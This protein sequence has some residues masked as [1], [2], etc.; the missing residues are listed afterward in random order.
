MD[1]SVASGRNV[2]A[3]SLFF[4][5]VD[6]AERWQSTEMD[7]TA[8][9]YGAAIPATY[10]DSP[11]PLQYYFELRDGPERVWLFPGFTPEL[12]NQPYFTPRRT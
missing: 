2:T 8:A 10:T 4:R 5:P 1:L 6:Q 9:G 11:Y 12:S 7:R 3:A